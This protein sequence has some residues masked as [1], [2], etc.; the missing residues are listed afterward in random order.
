MK[1]KLLLVILAVVVLAKNARIVIPE[2]DGGIAPYCIGT[3]NPNAKGY[4]VRR[5]ALQ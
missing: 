5:A 2:I 3:Q 4:L 1:K